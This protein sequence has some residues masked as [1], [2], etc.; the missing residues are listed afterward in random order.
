MP[1][2]SRPSELSSPHC[3]TSSKTRRCGSP[4]TACRASL[5]GLWVEGPFHPNPWPSTL[6]WPS[7]LQLGLPPVQDAFLNCLFHLAG[8]ISPQQ[9]SQVLRF[10]SHLRQNLLSSWPQTKFCA[11]SSMDQPPSLL[12]T[13]FHKPEK[14]RTLSENSVLNTYRCLRM[15]SG[16]WYSLCMG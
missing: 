9:S 12:F 8:S 2:P 15:Y 10:S 4:N 6:L 14:N 16:F 1:P 11:L 3:P 5:L 7:Q 13:V